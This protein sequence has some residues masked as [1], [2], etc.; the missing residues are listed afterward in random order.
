MRSGRRV[1]TG[2]RR[3][4]KPGSSRFAELRDQA[5]FDNFVCHGPL[6]I[7]RSHTLHQ[8]CAT[9]KLHSSAIH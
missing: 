9:P 2:Q 5:A 1:T 6:I 7:G 4:Y 3:G 8:L